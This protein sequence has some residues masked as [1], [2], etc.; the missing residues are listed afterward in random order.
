MIPG[1]KKGMNVIFLDTAGT[2]APLGV[3]EKNQTPG[4][5]GAMVQKRT[6]EM[7]LQ[8]LAFAL[9]DTLIVVVKELTWP[10]QEFLNVL[11]RKLHESDKAIK[12]LY[13]IHNFADTTD[14]EELLCLWRVSPFLPIPLDGC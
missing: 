3:K 12:E 10:D 1:K 11:Q 5:Q 13:V 4:E 2:N 8:E 9:A 14:E 6:T 7:F